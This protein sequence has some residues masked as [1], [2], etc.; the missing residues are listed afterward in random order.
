MTP[1]LIQLARHRSTAV[2]LAVNELDIGEEKPEDY[3]DNK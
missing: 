3:T 1:F 2:N